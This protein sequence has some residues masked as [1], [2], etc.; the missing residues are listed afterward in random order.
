[1]TEA[2][3]EFARLVPAYNAISSDMGQYSSHDALAEGLA[4]AYVKK[5][6]P[7]GKILGMGT[8]KGGWAKATNVSINTSV[9]QAT[10]SKYL[11][12]RVV[13]KVA[14]PGFKYPLAYALTLY[15][16]GKGAYVHPNSVIWAFYKG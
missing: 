5:L 12:T 16:E 13:V 3:T 2:S 9:T 1:V 10:F 4:S 14:V 8:L 11:S 6:Q 15:N 7:Q